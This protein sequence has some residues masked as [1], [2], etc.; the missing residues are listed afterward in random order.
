VAWSGNSRIQ[1]RRASLQHFRSGAAVVVFVLGALPALA[2]GIGKSPLT[3]KPETTAKVFV[4]VSRAGMR[5][6]LKV[7]RL[8]AIATVTAKDGLGTT[9]ITRANITLKAKKK[10]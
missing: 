5:V 2:G 6:L 7:G 4:K 3:I 1:R 8:G 9:K 10:G